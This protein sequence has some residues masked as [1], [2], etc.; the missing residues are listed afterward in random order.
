VLADVLAVD[1]K[2]LIPSEPRVEILRD[3]SR[4][5]PTSG[6]RNLLAEDE[7]ALGR[8]VDVDRCEVDPRC[9]SSALGLPQRNFAAY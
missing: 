9:S 2:R 7:V 5:L 3:G 1:F 8:V 6:D 4:L